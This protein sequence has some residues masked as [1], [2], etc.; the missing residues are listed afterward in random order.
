MREVA[1]GDLVF[2][3][4]NT[5][6]GAFGIARSYAYEA[7]KPLEFGTA[8]RNWDMI[9]WR[10]D[11]AFST[12]PRPYRPADWIERLRPLLPERYSPVLDDGRGVQSI[13]L[14]ELPRALALVLADLIGAE[15]GALARNELGP[16]TVNPGQP[17]FPQRSELALWE[18]HLSQ[19]IERDASI[20]ATEKEAI[21]LARRGQGRFR[22]LVFEREKH[23]RVTRVDRIEHLRASHCKPWR[24]CE[25]NEERLDADNGLMLTPS[26]DHL[27][28]RGFISFSDEGRVLV[29][30]VAHCES[31][32]KMGVATGRAVEVG[33]FR[34][35]Q[36]RYLEYHRDLVFLRAKIR[37]S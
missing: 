9:G 7:P 26:I 18:E 24:D 35:E 20:P 4:A 11:V 21:V 6:I 17:T 12:V 14:T 29:S 25:Q 22:E 15:V 33:A 30:P 13:Y 32:E 19:E 27:F 37:A 36:K 23:C 28:D 8:G 1:P 31:L 10:V 34:A 3:F 2:S 16:E 5:R